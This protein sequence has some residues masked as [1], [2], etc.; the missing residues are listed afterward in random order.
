[1]ETTLSS[2]Y[3]RAL[4][5][6]TIVLALTESMELTPEQAELLAVTLADREPAEP[7]DAAMTDGQLDT[8][9]RE[10]AAEHQPDSYRDMAKAF[11]AAG[12]SAG[13]N[14]LRAAWRRV[15]TATA[16]GA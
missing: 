6:G 8:V 12:H 13:E 1:M 7:T 4:R 14:R 16:E 2:T 5:V 11:R 15:T 3:T 10:V 9:V